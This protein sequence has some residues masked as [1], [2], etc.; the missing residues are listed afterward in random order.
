MSAPVARFVEKLNE[1]LRFIQR[2][3]DAFDAGM[4]DEAL[5]IATAM[6]VLLHQ[7]QSSTSLITHLALGVPKMLSSSRGHGDYRDYL[8]HRINFSSPVPIKMLP[9]L[10]EKFREMPLSDW[11][12]KEPVF[13]HQAERFTRKKII[14]S[15]ANKDGGAHVDVQ[16]ERYY[17]VLCAGEY[18]IGITGSFT[19]DGAPPFKQ[20]VRHYPKNAHLA[21]IRQFGHEVLASSSGWPIPQ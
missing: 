13:V 16:L 19:Y 10:G 7:T 4:E 11:W 6:R 2:S 8:A 17:E 21:L 15:A 20:G 12:S 9:L 14:L 1:Q 5:R 18:A 3:C